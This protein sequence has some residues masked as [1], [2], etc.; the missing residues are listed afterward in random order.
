MNKFA[1]ILAAGKGTR[2]KSDKDKVLHPLLGKP[3]ISHVIDN[4]EGLN[5]TKK[6][7]VISDGREDIKSLLKNEVDFVVQHERLG[8]GHAV[9][10]TRELLEKEIGTTLVI[11]GDTPLIKSE[12]IAKLFEIHQSNQA[13]ITILSTTVKEPYGYGRIV[14]NDNNEVVKIVEEKDATIEEKLITEINTGTYCFNNQLLFQS[15]LELKNDNAQNEYYLTDVVKV[16]SAHGG[17]ICAYITFD[18]EETL[19]INDRVALEKANRILKCRVNEKL[20]QNGVTII[21][22]NNTYISVDTVIGKDTTIYPGTI[23]MGKNI[24]GNNCDIGP[25]TQLENITIG[26]NVNVCQSV[27]TDCTI[28]NN[29]KVGPFAHFRNQSVIGDNVRIGN[30][31]EVK[32]TK[33]DKYSKAAHLS[34][35]GDAEIGKNVNVGCG[36]ITVNYDGKNKYQTIIKDNV[37]VGCNSNLIAPVTI[38]ENAY[39]AAGSTINRDV[40][41]DSLAIARSKQENKVGYAKKYR[42]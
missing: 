14:R 34:Y 30:F 17:K 31:V 29:T 40:P 3:M 16:V 2:M 32:N 6:V 42:K 23:C 1:V 12:T 26:N 18:E 5:L 4:L 38:A 13:D 21:D 41:S 28:G 25:N 19:G 9:K 7:V 35:I 37:F 8:T 10:M 22:R 11:C 15:L 36:S 27:I 24:I 39:I 20:M 33:I